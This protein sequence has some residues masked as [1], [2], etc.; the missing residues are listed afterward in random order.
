MFDIKLSS[1]IATLVEGMLP[2]FSGEK[3]LVIR[4]GVT[5]Y[6][7]EMRGD[8]RQIRETQ[9]VF[10]RKQAH[11]KVFV[12]DRKD[13]QEPLVWMLESDHDSC[14]QEDGVRTPLSKLYFRMCNEVNPDKPP[15]HLDHYV[16]IEK[17]QMFD[18][19]VGIERGPDQFGPGRYLLKGFKGI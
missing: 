4:L 16:T 14:W 3:A 10:E 5:V 13:R 7:P 8:D 17:V 2:R 6:D 11:T 1:A 12:A 15:A 19:G 9:M 18:E